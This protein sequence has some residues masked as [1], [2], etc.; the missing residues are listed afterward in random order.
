MGHNMVTIMAFNERIKTTKENLNTKPVPIPNF[1][2]THQALAIGDLHGNAMKG[3]YFLMRYGVM[4]LANEDDYSTLKNIY[5]K[6]TD[7]LTAGDLENFK[8]ILENASFKSPKLITF[9]GDELADRGNNDWFTLLLLDKLHRSKVP[10]QIQ[11]SNHS[12]VALQSIS[13]LAA[14]PGV[15]RTKYSNQQR[16][17][18][19]MWSLEVKGLITKKDI[20]DIANTSYK[21]HLRL[22]GYTKTTG[23]ELTIYTHAPVGLE[24]IKALASHFKVA[25]HEATMEE[26]IATIDRINNKASDS[27]NKNEFTQYFDATN[28]EDTNPIN[29]L[30][31]AR[32]LQSDFTLTPENKTYKVTCIHGHI[33]PAENGNINYINS[34]GKTNQTKIPDGLINLDSHWGMLPQ[35]NEGDCIIYCDSMENQLI[36]GLN[37]A[38]ELYLKYLERLH[39]SSP[40]DT[41]KEKI[42]LIESGLNILDDQQLSEEV[43]INQ[44]TNSIFNTKINFYGSNSDD[45]EKT[46]L[47]KIIDALVDFA[48]YLSPEWLDK[49]AIYS[50]FLL[51]ETEQLFVSKVKGVS[52]KTQYQGITQDKQDGEESTPTM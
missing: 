10:Y 47:I 27:I 28:S 29:T 5:D 7:S 19:N 15:I 38:C 11:Y 23:D 4:K 37:K 13:K 30:V 25:Y 44:F 34:R 50:H 2:P 26:L 51:K 39:F 43:K 14:L 6:N 3:I 33:G 16:S 20:N 32:A 36:K 24:T 49:E 42:N 22:I 31:W 17:L 1:D 18:D 40:S 9:I 52:F 8:H 46:L 45:V 48:N 35:D 12:S 21:P 41:T